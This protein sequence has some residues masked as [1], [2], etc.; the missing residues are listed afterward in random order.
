[1]Q[2]CMIDIGELV[3]ENH[4]LKKIDKYVDFAFIY[5]LARPYYS[6]TGRKSVAPVVMV[7]LLLIG[8]LYGI[9]SERP[10]SQ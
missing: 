1:M 6:N 10:K 2:I 5:E 3:S 4:L 9:K 8:Y 7:K